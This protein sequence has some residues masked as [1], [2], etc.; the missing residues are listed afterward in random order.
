MEHEIRALGQLHI[1]NTDRWFR[2]VFGVKNKY[3]SASDPHCYWSH[4]SWWWL[5]EGKHD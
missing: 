2:Q 5:C 4:S 1:I 3:D